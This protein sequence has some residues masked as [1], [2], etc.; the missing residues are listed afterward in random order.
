M[1][2]LITKS[3]RLSFILFLLTT[4][5]LAGNTL[6][7]EPQDRIIGGSFL[8]LKETSVALVLG[9]DYRCSG[10]LVGA[11]EV[12]TAAH[13][14]SYPDEINVLV[15]GAIY[16]VSEAW[17]HGYYDS[18]APAS[19]SAPYDLGMLILSVPVAAIS[20]TPVLTNLPVQIGDQG[21]IFGYGTNEL[22]GLPGRYPWEDGKVGDMVVTSISNG[23]L[24]SQHFL[25][26]ASACPGDSGGP[27]IRVYGGY[28]SVMGILSV[29]VNQSYGSTCYLKA[30]GQYSYV[31]L[32]S[33]SSRRFLNNFP[34]VHYISGYRILVNII[35]KK[36]LGEIDKARRA[37]NVKIVTKRVNRALKD[38]KGLLLF[39]DGT[40]AYLLKSARADLKQTKGSRALTEMRAKLKKAHNKV[41]HVAKMGVY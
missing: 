34:G 15:G 19:A 33:S 22:S 10:V 13:C 41:S 39:A 38:I 4:L 40:R 28:A 11:R 21:Y 29:G 5:F 23:L 25:T 37:N 6:G 9:E 36:V 27:A 1:N 24:S 35:S 14:V 26:G 30:D 31:D 7:Q 32:Q 18:N 16:G 17:Y 2:Q 3:R 20:P 8:D 12:L